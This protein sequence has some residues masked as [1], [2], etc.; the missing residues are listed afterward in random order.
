[1]NGSFIIGGVAR[2]AAPN[3]VGDIVDA[4]LD[5]FGRL[6][7]A[8]AQMSDVAEAAGVSVGTLY[9]YVEGKEALLLLCALYAFDP[10][11]AVSGERPLNVARKGFLAKLR[12]SLDA[13][14]HLPALDAALARNSPPSDVAAECAQII[15]ELFD[16]VAANRRGLDALERSAR[17]VPDVAA[18]FY[19][20]VRLALLENLATYVK[21]HAPQFDA[22]VTA[23]WAVESITWMARH[24]HGDPDGHRLDDATVRSSTVQLI[25]RAITGGSA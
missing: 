4:A 7:Y 18:L 21:R 9:N 14:A 2:V 25:T 11:A 1:V 3:R 6:G 19:G 20:D 8:R 12:R 10:D 13:M 24:R 16:L 22:R 5:V 15:G 17:D 23:R